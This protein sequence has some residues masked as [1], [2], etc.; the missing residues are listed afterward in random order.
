M[1]EKVSAHGTPRGY[2]D[3]C[4]G[5]GACDNHRTGRMT[6]TE[7][8]VRYQGDYAYR[9]A[10]DAGTATTEKESFAVKKGRVIQETKAESKK[11]ATRS[12][13][14]ATGTPRPY[15][16]KPIEHGTRRG[17]DNGCKTDC[18]N[19]VDGGISCID[20]RRAIMQANHITRQAKL[21]ASRPADWKPRFTPFKHGTPSGAD[22]CKSE[23]PSEA[24]GGISCMRAR[25]LYQRD[26]KA[27][28]KLEAQK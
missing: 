27:Q 20:A 13:R 9:V 21:E 2:D 3:G 23:C 5:S 14:K 26:R 8:H 1:G 24:A 12:I 17:A 19:E 18:P 28:L 11:R 7:A 4:R 6:C 16:K 10:V 22:K 15:Q 25:L